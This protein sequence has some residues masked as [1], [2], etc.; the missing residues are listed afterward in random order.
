MLRRSS[1]SNRKNGI[2]PKPTAFT[3]FPQMQAALPSQAF[4]IKRDG[5]QS[6][7]RLRNPSQDAVY[8][9]SGGSRAHVERSTCLNNLE[10]QANRRAYFGGLNLS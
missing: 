6:F 2:S 10:R 5:I 8:V 7:R 1:Q 4:Y 9:S 3:D